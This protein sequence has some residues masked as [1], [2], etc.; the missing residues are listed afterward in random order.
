MRKKEA[1]RGLRK[2][3][4]IN[5]REGQGLIEMGIAPMD[6]ILPAE[7]PG[8]ALHWKLVAYPFETHL[9]EIF[10]GSYD[11]IKFSYTGYSAADL[12]FHPMSGILL[13][14]KPV[15]IFPEKQPWS[16]I[17]YTTDG[18]EPTPQSPVIDSTLRLSGP[19]NLTVRSFCYHAEFDK[20]FSGRFTVGEALKPVALPRSAK[21]GGWRYG[22]YTG[23]W[24]N[25]PDFK[26][27]KPVLSGLT[28][29]ALKMDTL[30]VPQ[31]AACVL[32]G[33]LEVKE[34]GYYIFVVKPVGATKW[35]LGNQSLIDY[36]GV[37]GQDQYRSFVLPLVKG[38]YPLRLE[39]LLKKGER[40]PLCLYMKPGHE[41]PEPFDAALLY[42]S[43]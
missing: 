13:K 40:L 16:A 7:G 5:G 38:F 12:V 15:K 41:D 9:S 2:T 36:D 4:W 8:T 42:Y 34:E 35:S 10:K 3:L 17:H 21:P 11:G 22:Y 43:E 18:S 19:A 37:A 20:T 1:L 32:T 30:A 31:T 33:W 6:T 29:K 27:L 14:D 26:K 24:K 28:K 23:D 39:T 25:L